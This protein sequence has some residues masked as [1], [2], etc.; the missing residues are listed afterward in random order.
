MGQPW[1]WR[2][3]TTL[4]SALPMTVKAQSPV[5]EMSLTLAP[6]SMSKEARG[7]FATLL[8]IIYQEVF[9]VLSLKDN[10]SSVKYNGNKDQN[11]MLL[12]MHIIAEQMSLLG[13]YKDVTLNDE[14]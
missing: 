11:A 1:L 14:I 2:A 3:F 10:T 6:F 13:A 7:K 9:S 12:S 5:S 8:E 4:I